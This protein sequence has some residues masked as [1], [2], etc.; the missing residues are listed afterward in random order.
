MNK[1]F[2]PQ[3]C[4]RSCPL[5]LEGPLSSQTFKCKMESETSAKMEFQV[6]EKT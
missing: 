2:P 1:P 5:P 3:T 4:R 6:Q